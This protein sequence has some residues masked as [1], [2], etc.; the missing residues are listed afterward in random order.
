MPD[1]PL[2]YIVT[3]MRPARPALALLLVLLVTTGSPLFASGSHTPC[4]A[5][6]ECSDTTR[7]MTCCCCHDGSSVNQ[8]GVT[9]GRVEIG[10]D[11][12]PA[13][14]VGRLAFASSSSCHGV[15]ATEASPPHL[16]AWDFVILFADLR[17]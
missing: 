2:E 16:P 17:L 13:V 3:G 10:A 1:A 9:L 11:Q 6:P 12:Q 8:P 14:A 4:S 15:G 7:M 5:Q